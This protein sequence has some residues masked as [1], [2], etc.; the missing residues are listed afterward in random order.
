[1]TYRQKRSGEIAFFLLVSFF[2]LVVSTILIASPVQL[3]LVLGVRNELVMFLYVGICIAGVV[4]VLFPTACSRAVGVRRASLENSLDLWE[5]ATRVLG[6]LIIHGHHTGSASNRHEVRFRKK[7][8]CATCY[9]LLSGAVI[10]IAIVMDYTLSSWPVGMGYDFAKA[11]YAV[12]V[13]GVLLGFV[14]LFSNMGASARFLLA[15]VFVVG[16]SLMLVATDVLTADLMADLFVVL[17]ALFWL[18]SRIWLSH[19][20]RDLSA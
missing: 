16:T 4:A 20:R 3:P 12:G 14:Q 15:Q 2:G 18:L 17:L 1:M 6:I 11:L 13:L 5:R 10:S 7:S 9:G 8:F 19:R